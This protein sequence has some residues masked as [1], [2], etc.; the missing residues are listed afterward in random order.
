MASQ[1]PVNLPRAIDRRLTKAE[2]LVEKASLSTRLGRSRRLLKRAA[3]TARKGG[4]KTTRLAQKGTITGTCSTPLLDI[5]S[6]VEVKA[7]AL[8]DTLAAAQTPVRSER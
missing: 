6:A 4:R 8:R 5:F 1:C 2:A 3:R 7:T